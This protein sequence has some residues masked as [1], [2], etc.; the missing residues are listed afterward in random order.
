MQIPLTSSVRM[1]VR[2]EYFSNQSYSFGQ[3]SSQS[4]ISNEMISIV[5]IENH[6]H[7]AL[8]EVSTPPGHDSWFGRRDLGKFLGKER[9][10]PAHYGRVSDLGFSLHR[11]YR[12]L[13]DLE[14]HYGKWYFEQLLQEQAALSVMQPQK[15]AWR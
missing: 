13:L 4:M 8:T 14:P 15:I 11:K 1:R 7:I 6:T 3:S 10:L 9:G 12:N 2:C 5:N